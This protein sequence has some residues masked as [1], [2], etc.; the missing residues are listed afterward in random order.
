[1]HQ[2]G[3]AESALAFLSFSPLFMLICKEHLMM[4]DYAMTFLRKKRGIM[5][6]GGISL[7][8]FGGL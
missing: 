7:F 2:L 6:L 5:W 3:P 4:K 1:M 8:M